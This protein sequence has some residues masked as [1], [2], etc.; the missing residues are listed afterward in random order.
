MSETTEQP[1]FGWKKTLVY[2]LLPLLLLAVALEGGARLWELLA[3]PLPVDYG[4]GFNPESRLFAPSED[5]PEVYIT[6]PPKEVSFHK[7]SFRVPKPPDRFRIFFLGGSNVN[8][9]MGDLGWSAT[10][11]AFKLDRK[12]V[13]EFIDAGGLAYGS[14]RLTA[15]TAEIMDYQPDLILIYSGHN[16]FEELE[17]LQLAQLGGLPLQRI[18]YQSAFLRFARDR[19]ALRQVSRIERERNAEILGEPE[20]DHL[21]GGRHQYSPEEIEQRMEEY[22]N[23]LTII[24]SLCK[25][26]A[27]PVILGTV[28]SNLYTPYFFNR[29][30]E[31]RLQE[32]YERGAYEEGMALAREMLLTRGRHQ[33][34]DAENAILR[35]LAKEFNVPLADV[36]AA[37]IAAEPH[38]VPGETLFSDLCHVN[39]N[40]KAILLQVFEEKIVAIFEGRPPF[41]DDVEASE[42]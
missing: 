30:D 16:E 10:R 42:K 14:H 18:L 29:E 19:L 40:G 8:Y 3:P 36:E 1:R 17:Q 11:L 20:V 28:P 21:A 35:S 33:A 31:V 23:N 22:R 39:G 15:I 4:W 13:F 26:N 41:V 34:S 24:L 32:I 2:S 7:Q 37:I 38:G 25:G 6:N 5:D 9:L 12:R 27:V